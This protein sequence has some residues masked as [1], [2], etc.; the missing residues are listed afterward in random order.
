[1]RL[2]LVLEKRHSNTSFGGVHIVQVP[3]PLEA[4]YA[5]GKLMLRPFGIDEPDL[6]VDFSQ[7]SR[8]AL[9][10]DILECCATATNG[11]CADRDQ[12]WALPVSTRIECLLRIIDLGGAFEAALPLRCLNQTCGETVEAEISLDDLLGRQRQPAELISVQ[13]GEQVLKLRRP[14]GLDQRAWATS[15]FQSQRAAVELMVE[16]LLVRDDSS[17]EQDILPLDDEALSTVDQAMQEGDS[18]I[19]FSFEIVCPYCD[20]HSEFELDLQ[21]L[22]IERLQQSQRRLMTTVHHLARC[23]HWSEQDIFAVPHWRRVHYLKLLEEERI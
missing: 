1:L 22:A 12:L 8:P 4:T 10:T 3:T 14:S 9:V 15:E 20:G 13:C 7:P 19:N 17:V 23:Y 18:L 5:I 2:K 16:T 6:E 11:S 21:M